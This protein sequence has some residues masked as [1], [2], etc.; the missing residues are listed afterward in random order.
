MPDDTIAR[1]KA[2]TRFDQH[3]SVWLFGYGSLIFKADFPFIERRPAHIVG[4]SRR[5]WQGSHDHR[6][7]VQVPGRVATLIK[8]EDATCAGMAY[9]IAP[10]VFDHLDHR[11]KNGYLRLSVDILFE[12][13]SSTAGSIYVAPEENVAFLGPASE[14]EIAR[15]I[16][17]AKGASGHNA[18][19]LFGLAMALRKL[20][21]DDSHVFEI[22]RHLQLLDIPQR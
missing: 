16:A 13:G 6:G 1:N 8:D 5:F 21:K 2:M 4:W 14:A 10:E 11:E 9:L 15:Q 17:T 3:D 7:T 22:E 19:Y 18:D 12:D 20:D